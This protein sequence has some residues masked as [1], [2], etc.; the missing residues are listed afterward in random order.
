M[1]DST[2]STQSRGASAY[3]NSIAVLSLLGISA[4]L[5]MKYG[6]TLTNEIY[7]FKINTQLTSGLT[8]LHQS[9]I[10]LSTSLLQLPL[11]V[12]LLLGG[13]PLLYKLTDK[14]LR[15]DFGSDLLAGISI[16]TAVSLNEYLHRKSV[17]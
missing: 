15:G 14:L 17:D 3:E 9:Q 7:T 11:L 6:F 5:V 16:I 4:Y 10:D 12:V 1:T 8:N 2:K 13:I